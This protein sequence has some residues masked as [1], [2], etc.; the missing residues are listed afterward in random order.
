MLSPVPNLPPSCRRALSGQLLTTSSP[1]PLAALPAPHVAAFV[2]AL[3]ACCQR[4]GRPQRQPPLPGP[5]DG[6]AAH[7]AAAA[8]GP[9]A[10]GAPACPPPAA[11]AAHAA[12]VLRHGVA[13]VLDGAWGALAGRLGQLSARQTADVV[14]G[15]AACGYDNGEAYDMVGG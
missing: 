2:R 11:R 15:L 12:E 9:S 10:S 14:G 1:S 6:P 13:G 7:A 5:A 8:L 4:L 3:G